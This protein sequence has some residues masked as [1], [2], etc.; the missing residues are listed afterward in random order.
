MFVLIWQQIR[1]VNSNYAVFQY[2]G[3]VC[4]IQ[5]NMKTFQKTKYKTVDQGVW[6]NTVEKLN[7]KPK[8]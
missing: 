6:G 8:L 1:F 3:K 4:R 2:Y 7:R 5:K